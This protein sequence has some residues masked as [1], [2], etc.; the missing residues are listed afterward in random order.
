MIPLQ[1]AFCNEVLI[2]VKK[3]KTVELVIDEGWHS[4]SELKEL[5]WSQSPP[6]SNGYLSYI[7]RKPTCLH[8]VP[9]VRPFI[10]YIFYNMFVQLRQKITGAKTRCLGLGDTHTRQHIKSE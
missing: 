10:P 1:E 4:E 3:K 8:M 7:R 2:L 5:G 6:Q 9:S